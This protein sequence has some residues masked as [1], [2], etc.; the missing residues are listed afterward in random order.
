[1]NNPARVT[2]KFIVLYCLLYVSFSNAQK[3]ESPVKWGDIPKADLEMK[4]CPL[5]SSAEAMVLSDF[6]NSYFDDE[7]NII[8]YHHLRVKIFNKQ[9]FDWGTHNFF[10]NK[11]NER[12]RNISGATYVLNKNGNIDTYKLNKDDIFQENVSDETVSYKFTLP[13][14]EPGC[15]IE[16][17]Y[18]IVTDNL[19]YM[20]DWTF[21]NKVPTRWSEYNIVTPKQIAYTIVPLGYEPYVVNNRSEIKQK[22]DGPAREI[23]GGEETDCW[24]YRWVTKDI[25][26]MKDEPYVTTTKNYVNRLQVQ[27][28]GYNTV[29]TGRKLILTTWEDVIAK[30]LDSD[31]LCN[32]IDDNKTVREATKKATEGLKTSMD[33]MK[34]IYDWVKT[35]IVWSGENRF[36]AE[37]DPDDVIESRKGNSSDIAILLISMLKSAGIKA[38]PVVLSTRSNGYIQTLY[39]I[40]SQ[41]NYV[42]ARAYIPEDSSSYLLD[43]TNPYRPY[44]LLPSKILNVTGLVIKEG[45]PEWITITSNKVSSR[46]SSIN[47][48]VQSDGTIKGTFEINLTNYEGLEFRSD[49]D[50]KSNIEACKNYFE[51]GST[52]ISIDSVTIEGRKSEGNIKIRGQFN[53]PEYAQ[54]SNNTIYLNPC[55]IFKLKN[56]PFKTE[57]RH[58]PVDYGYKRTTTDLITINFPEGFNLKDTYGAIKYN[59]DKFA[60]YTSNGQLID[61]NKIQIINKT[62]IK[63]TLIAPDYYDALKSFYSKIVES[64]GKM[65]VLDKNNTAETTK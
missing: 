28:L 36:S 32:R 41:F 2:F 11:K 27:L 33:K 42:I 23:L 1:M 62:E 17:E 3:P 16:I 49:N 38:D 18:E 56:N 58:F 63:E 24:K 29:S 43:A 61:G 37:K 45:A 35:S 12:P 54:V 13:N 22:I 9:G 34:A 4:S 65:L 39:P 44:D 59:L 64:Q 48:N 19:S 47:V 30:L 10:L 6:G 21:Q 55:I 51:L 31:Y 57:H 7:L 52:G 15:I 40:V 8:F 50:E 60:S 46:L 20:N 25:P 14:L 26:A 5:D 53:S